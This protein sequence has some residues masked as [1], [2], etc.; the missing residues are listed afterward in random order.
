MGHGK[1]FRIIALVE[2][3]FSTTRSK[4]LLEQLRCAARRQCYSSSPNVEY[5]GLDIDPDCIAYAQRTY[6]TRGTLILGE[7]QS[8]VRV[9][10]RFR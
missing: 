3:P 2:S 7:P 5:I 6:D 9:D 1:R 8:G 4:L 10:S